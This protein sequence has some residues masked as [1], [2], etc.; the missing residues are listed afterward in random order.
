MSRTSVVLVG[1]VRESFEWVLPTAP[2]CGCSPEPREWVLSAAL[3]RSLW[4]LP[5]SLTCGYSRLRPGSCVVT[6]PQ[7]SKRRTTHFDLE[8]APA[9]AFR[10]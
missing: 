10:G 5:W 8:L 2:S 1:T 4:V 7:G 6:P 9:R 3:S